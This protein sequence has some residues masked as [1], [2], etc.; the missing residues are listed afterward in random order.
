MP[1]P[2]VGSPR[3]SPTTRA[4]TPNPT[5]PCTHFGEAGAGK[6]SG[7]GALFG[8]TPVDHLPD[9]TPVYGGE[10]LPPPF[11]TSCRAQM[12]CPPAP[13]RGPGPRPRPRQRPKCQASASSGAPVGQM[14]RSSRRFSP[15]WTCSFRQVPSTQ[16]LRPPRQRP[17]ARA[18]AFC[19]APTPTRSGQRTAQASTSLGLQRPSVQQLL[20]R[21]LHCVAVGGTLFG[22]A[23]Q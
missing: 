5:P 16:S 15:T 1:T 11:L 18:R 22:D 6:G 8:M 19:R 7:K 10:G 3:E 2:S 14:I 23:H 20:G 9:G 4:P 13:R 21:Q 17:R 12:S